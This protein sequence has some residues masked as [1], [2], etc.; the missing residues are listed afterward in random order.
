MKSKSILIA[1][2]VFN[3]GF[4][5]AQ[6]DELPATVAKGRLFTL[7]GKKLEFLNLSTSAEQYTFTD[8]AINRSQTILPDNVLRIEQQTG[9]E[10]GKWALYMG[11]AGLLGSTAGVLSAIND[12]KY[13]GLKTNDVNGAPIVV[14]LTLTSALVGALI[15]SGKK[16]YKTVYNNPMYGG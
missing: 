7:E 13:L 2:F 16:K 10:A 9:T 11:V 15:G 6:T 12:A 3:M 8:M 5:I 1:L 4:I 14:G